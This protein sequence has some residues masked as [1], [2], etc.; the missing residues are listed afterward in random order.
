MLTLEEYNALA[1]ADKAAAILNGEFLADREENGLMVELYS[2][3]SLYG[4][5][6]YDPL[7][8]R[9]LRWRALR[10]SAN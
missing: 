3:G 7:A 8:N 5:I 6:Y 9:I 2:F 10:A 1:E 4:E